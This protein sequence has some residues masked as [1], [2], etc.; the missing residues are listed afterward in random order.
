MDN[1]PLAG[2]PDTARKWGLVCVRANAQQ[3]ARQQEAGQ[4]RSAS[5]ACVR[6]G[7]VEYKAFPDGT[8]GGMPR[9]R[10]Y[11]PSGGT[12]GGGGRGVLRWKRFTIHMT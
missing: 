3:Q 11:N 7:E 2:P 9:K 4:E 10:G 12:A 1:R 5:A 8:Q 6:H